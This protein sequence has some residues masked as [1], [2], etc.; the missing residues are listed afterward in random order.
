MAKT[1]SSFRGLRFCFGGRRLS[2]L[3][4]TFYKSIVFDF[5]ARYASIGASLQHNVSIDHKWNSRTDIME[6]FK[7]KRGRKARFEVGAVRVVEAQNDARRLYLPISSLTR[8]L[9]GR[10]KE[11]D[12]PV[13][14]WTDGYWRVDWG[15]AIQARLDDFF[16][17][18]GCA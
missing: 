10:K 7:P 4:G 1:A 18:A 11:Q 8:A 15:E 17:K 13:G 2:R 14:V 16:R 3:E 5:R 6:Q 12:I 9:L